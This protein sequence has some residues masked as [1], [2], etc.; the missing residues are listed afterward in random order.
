MQLKMK[1]M[2]SGQQQ[3]MKDNMAVFSREGVDITVV[4]DA[5]EDIY[6]EPLREVSV[7]ATLEDINAIQRALDEKDNGEYGG[8]V[9][10]D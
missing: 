1:S 4:N 9:M 7:V 3:F 5:A 2:F 6:G 8:S 10:L